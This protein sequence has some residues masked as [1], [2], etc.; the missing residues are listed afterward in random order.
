M[1]ST[2]AND[3]NSPLW[4]S[5][6]VIALV[7]VV[8]A[9]VLFV[10]LV[11]DGRG[12]G[13][14]D[15]VGGPANG[16]DEPTVITVKRTPAASPTATLEPTPTLSP[17]EVVTIPCRLT[18]NVDQN[19]RVEPEC[20]VGALVAIPA[21]MAQGG[22][23]ATRETVDAL[24][25]MVA[26]AKTAGHRIYVV[27]SHRSYALQDQLFRE[28]VAKFGVNQNTVARPG[29]SEHQLG[30]TLDISSD[31]VGGQVTAAF[32]TTSEGQWLAQNATKYGFVVSYPSGREAETG[33]AYEPWHIRYVGP[34]VAAAQKASG[35]PLN[36]FLAERQ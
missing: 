26:D 32:G 19:H 21:E 25:R 27:S 2:T 23:A 7:A 28:E 36:R 13:D 22:Q 24:Q 9:G 18:A 16:G 10:V 5:L 17:G 1:P 33:Y 20:V 29:H 35:K 6:F 34:D 30:T 3:P 12:G 4:R 31:A 11:T 8:L 14:D 15:E